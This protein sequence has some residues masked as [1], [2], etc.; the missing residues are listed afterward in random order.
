MPNLPT[1]SL[2]QPQLERVIAVFG[3]AATYKR[4]LR[5]HL[6]D[7]VVAA[8]AKAIEARATAERNALVDEVVAV[9]SE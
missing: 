7:A 5:G 3:D 8:E 6:V 1:I 2:T 4:W 9:I